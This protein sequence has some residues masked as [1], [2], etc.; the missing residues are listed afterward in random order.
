MRRV[1]GRR[2]RA[3]A[4][5]RGRV[6]RPRRRRGRIRRRRNEDDARGVRRGASRLTPR[7]R[8]ILMLASPPRV[9]RRRRRERGVE[10]AVALRLVR[11]DARGAHEPDAGAFSFAL[12]PI[13][14]RQRG[15]RRSLR[16]F[17]P[18]VS[19]RPGS[20][21]F[22]PDT[23]RRLSTPKSDAFE[24][25]PDFASYGPSTLAQALHWKSSRRRG[26]RR[27]GP[28]ALAAASI[29]LVM[30]DL[31]RHVLQDGGVISDV[32]MY[33]AG[34]AHADVRCLSVVGAACA[35][36]TYLGFACLLAGT[37]WDAG[38]VTNARRALREHRHR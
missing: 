36:A 33:R 29:P 27:R 4:R 32:G 23:P 11:G 5:R 31:T 18:G 35:T 8:R 2:S 28:I 14:P 16:T 34:C 25:H 38:A 22:N 17:V 30:L 24:L 15:E 19:L 37:L 10:E 21:A 12:V 6:V 26:F 3:R 9:A 13:R 20:L 7:A 1:R